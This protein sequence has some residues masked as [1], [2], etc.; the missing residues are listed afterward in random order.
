[1][2]EPRRDGR[3]EGDLVDKFKIVRRRYPAD[4]FSRTT[5]SFFSFLPIITIIQLLESYVTQ[6]ERTKLLQ[7]LDGSLLER[8]LCARCCVTHYRWELKSFF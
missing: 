5:F 8:L 1:M 6:K 4:A 7:H 2:H 3:S